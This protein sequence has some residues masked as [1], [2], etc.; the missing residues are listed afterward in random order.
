MET[1]DMLSS[2]LPSLLF[3][4]YI[5]FNLIYCGSDPP[6]RLKVCPSSI[7]RANL[8]W[9]LLRGGEIVYRGL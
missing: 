2:L 8:N 1:C 4:Y 7:L 6:T 3:I 5:L 9:K